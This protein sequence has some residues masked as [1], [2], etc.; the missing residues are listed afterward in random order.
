MPSDLKF[1]KKGNDIVIEEFFK[2][3]ETKIEECKDSLV[4]RFNYICLIMKSAIKNYW[5]E[6]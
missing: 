3:L 5:R 2:L 6:V 4:E 1:E